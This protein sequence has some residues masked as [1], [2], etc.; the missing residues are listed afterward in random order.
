MHFLG[1]ALLWLCRGMFAASQLSSMAGDA[2]VAQAALQWI[3][4]HHILQKLKN[5]DMHSL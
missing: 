5:K 2:A 1:L 4:D 3:W